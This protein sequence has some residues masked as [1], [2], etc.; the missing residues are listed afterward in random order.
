M[1]DYT[2]TT[3]T[4]HFPVKDVTHK[5]KRMQ[6]DMIR[7]KEAEA[8]IQNSQEPAESTETLSVI[9]LE[10]AISY[11]KRMSADATNGKLY[12][13]T[14][15]WLEELLVTRTLKIEA[16]VKAVIEGESKDEATETNGDTEEKQPTV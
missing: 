15:K 5:P 10:R 16:A 12:S 1:S 6:G 7:L 8:G 2:T 13:A 14:A 9:T 4:S 3:T 11:Y